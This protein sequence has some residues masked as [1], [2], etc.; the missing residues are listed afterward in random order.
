MLTHAD[1]YGTF[2][3]S[4][5]DDIHLS[6]VNELRRIHTGEAGYPD[7]MQGQTY[8][9]DSISGE[10]VGLGNADRF[11]EY[12]NSGA[13]DLFTKGFMGGGGDKR[14]LRDEKWAKD[15]TDV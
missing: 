11:Q 5:L 6:T 2:E 12:A 3:Q 9:I 8:H 14:I 13:S 4:G 7:G 1:V 10:I 15:C